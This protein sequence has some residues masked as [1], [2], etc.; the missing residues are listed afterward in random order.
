MSK[1]KY[2]AFR[3]YEGICS[4]KNIVPEIAKVLSLGVRSNAVKDASGNVLLSPKVLRGQNWDIVYPA[5]DST[6]AISNDPDND[7]YKEMS[8][9]DY[10]AKINN[11]VAQIS[12]TVIL[13]TNITSDEVTDEEDDENLSSEEMVDNLTMYLEIY[14]PAYICNPEQYPL[15]CERQGIIPKLITEDIYTDALATIVTKEHIITSENINTTDSKKVSIT[16]SANKGSK[17]KFFNAVNAKT[18]ISKIYKIVGEDKANEAG[19]SIPDTLSPTSTITLSSDEVLS[20]RAKDIDLYNNLIKNV[21]DTL[22][23]ADIKKINELKITVTYSDAIEEE[24]KYSFIL[25]YT[26][27]KSQYTI[28]ANTS[29]NVDELFYDELF[30]KDGTQKA[31]ITTQIVPFYKMDGI[32]TPID[33]KKWEYDAASTS[34]HGIIFK[35]KIT[36]NTLDDGE[37]VFKYNITKDVTENISD[38][39]LVPNNHY[40]LMRM[41]DDLNETKDGPSESIYDSNGDVI[42]QR[43]HISDWCKYAWY[44]DF[45]EIYKDDIDTDVSVNNI[46]DGT[47]LVP[48]I[49][50]GLNSETKIRYWINTNNNRF[51]LVIM[52]N[53][54]LDIQR[55]RHLVSACYCGKI[56]SFDYSIS[57]VAG[58]FAL[59]VSSSTEPCNS[60]L[61]IEK[62][63]SSTTVDTTTL[64]QPCDVNKDQFFFTAPEGTFFFDGDYRYTIKDK[65]GNIVIDEQTVLTKDISA[66]DTVIITIPQYSYDNTYKLYLTYPYYTEDKKL[67]PGVE[68]DMFGNV[69]NVEK[70]NSWGKNTSDGT[71]SIMMYHTRSRAYYQKH[72]MM[73]TTTE[74]YMSKVMYGKSSYT[75]EYYADRIKVTHSNDGP[76]GMLND[77]LVID[78]HSLYPLDELV[79]NKDFAKEP[80]EYEET[81]IYFPVT[82]PYSPLSDSPNATYGIAIKKAEVAPAFTDENTTVDLAI[83]ELKLLSKNLWWGITEDI[84]PPS[85]VAVGNQ[86]CSV[87]WELIKETK[88]YDS[89]TSVGADK[90]C[91]LTLNL[92]QDS[93]M[94]GDTDNVLTAK[95]IVNENDNIA[96]CT[97][98]NYTGDKKTSK[99]KFTVSGFEP[100]DS[101]N[102]IYYGISSEDITIRN[103]DVIKLDIIPPNN[104]DPSLDSHHTGNYSY[105]I[106]EVPCVGE[107]TETTEQTLVL[108]NAKPGDKLYIYE[109]ATDTEDPYKHVVVKYAKTVLTQ[110]LLKYP[111]DVVIKIVSGNGKVVQPAESY[112]TVTYGDTFV[113]K[114]KTETDEIDKVEVIANDETTVLP[115]TAYSQSGNTIQITLTD[116]TADTEVQVSLKTK[117]SASET[118]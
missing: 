84:Y 2:N 108:D 102:S 85:E 91:G 68:R 37:I 48:L 73:F 51:D 89:S 60:K 50:A 28:E 53:P 105:Y 30:N 61:E 47:L 41:Y 111:S 98:A 49:T 70:T 99:I 8:S 9:E 46:A 25:D 7:D 100:D 96:Q 90:Y 72:H 95:G 34:N 29:F 69:I 1:Q 6:F 20:I 112:A 45:E 5:P 16:S 55:E 66:E 21:L 106:K 14:K 97:D 38:R 80:E 118:P 39:V 42:T 56:D 52:G 67:T 11:Q 104:N 109:V 33:E 31:I 36:G 71:T 54:S 75:N 3:Y 82:A 65:D 76:R 116:V 32:Y 27:L 13:R 62:I 23:D 81:Y 78:S 79:I 4:T 44:R 77:M 12:D 58:N 24:E 103:G 92:L 117:T 43:A 83:D 101:N 59:F 64:I 114:V 10:V 88:W 15:D 115:D 74:E 22:N 87:L 40:I 57:D 93:T 86:K 18:Y 26:I 35:E 17:Y 113:I 107:I 110:K 94:I 63:K 19:F